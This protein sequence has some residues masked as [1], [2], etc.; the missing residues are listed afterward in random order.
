MKRFFGM[1]V[2]GL[3]AVA[4]S[5]SALAQDSGF[6]VGAFG[7]AGFVSD[8]EGS[9]VT[10]ETDRTVEL[11]TAF[12]GNLQVGYD[13]GNVLV[14]LDLGYRNVGIDSITNATGV[15]GDIDVGTAF[16]T[17]G[18]E[19]D[20]EKFDPFIRVGGGGIVGD[21]DVSFTDTIDANASVSESETIAAPAIQAQVGFAY[22]VTEKLDLVAAYEFMYI[23]EAELNGTSGREDISESVDVHSIRLGFS[24]N[25]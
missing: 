1:F 7:T 16:L 21:A 3:V 20:Q 13:F 25:F 5:G 2:A 9:F 15:D 14:G 8:L 12:G 4:A 10:G 18:Y 19:L 6:Y 22:A 24:Y 17:V 23:I 11:E